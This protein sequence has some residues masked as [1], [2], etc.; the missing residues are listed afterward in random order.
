M[1]RRVAVLHHSLNHAGG[2][3]RVC[4]E[5]IDVLLNMG[6][7]VTLATIEPTD[8][9]KITKIFGVKKPPIEE[10]TLLGKTLGS[11]KRLSIYKRLLSSILIPKLRKNHELIINTHGDVLIVPCDINYMH[12]PTF[13]LRDRG[14][15]FESDI[16]YQKSFFWK[17]YFAPYSLMEDFAK[18]ITPPKVILTNSKFSAYIIRRF[19]KR[20]AIVVYP[21]VDVVKIMNKVKKVKREDIVISIGRIAQDKH[22]EKIPLIASKTPS[23]VKF[24]IMGTRSPE[25]EKVISEIRRNMKKY[26]VSKDRVLILV[27]VPEE[28]KIKI[29]NKAKVFLHAMKCEH[30]GMAV[31]EAM[32]TGLIPVVHKSGGPWFDILDK[33]QGVYGYAY[34]NV[35]EA[36]SY[37]VAALNN[38]D[39]LV[40]NVINRA[41]YFS[42]ENFRKTISTIILNYYPKVQG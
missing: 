23:H 16:K 22:Y 10:I 15:F 17:I 34:K 14:L 32:A 2:G 37:I 29:M 38:Y 26:N 36:S 30:F 28:V 27:D 19:L 35:E 11:F 18:E 31:V 9:A 21:P 8:W 25:T 40:D 6:F 13:A 7:R 12:F 33:K 5:I 41:K 42:K 39:Q 4:L 3:E 20:R 1:M 24:I